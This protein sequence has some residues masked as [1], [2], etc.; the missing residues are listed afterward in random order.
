MEVL[1]RGGQRDV[2]FGAGTIHR[3]G[4]G[5]LKRLAEREQASLQCNERQFEF[6]ACAGRL[7]FVERRDHASRIRLS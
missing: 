3:F 6:H 1:H 2:E 4:V 5:L 7:W